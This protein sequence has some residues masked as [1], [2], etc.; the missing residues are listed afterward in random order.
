MAFQIANIAY[1]V[2]SNIIHTQIIVCRLRVETH[3]GYVWPCGG[4]MGTQGE[5]YLIG[6]DIVWGLGP[7]LE[8]GTVYYISI[9]IILI[10]HCLQSTSNLGEKNSRNWDLN[11]PNVVW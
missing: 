2:K 7:Q 4:T 6:W 9:N 5:V 8:Q 1:F 3:P 11:R 10:V